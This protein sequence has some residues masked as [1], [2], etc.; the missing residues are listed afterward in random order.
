MLLVNAREKPGM[1]INILQYTGQPSTGKNDPKS[2]VPKNSALNHKIMY[3]FQ[4]FRKIDENEQKFWKY[5]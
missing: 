3:R 2:Q 4:T 1:V 5:T